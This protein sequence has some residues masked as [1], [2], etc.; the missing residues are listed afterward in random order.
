MNH[1]CANSKTPS[2]EHQNTDKM[3]KL[4]FTGQYKTP[5][6]KYLPGNIPAAAGFNS[7]SDER[8]HAKM[9]P[10]SPVITNKPT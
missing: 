5:F 4:M 3:T 8:T 9:Q 10:R 7:D 6:M 2:F 1:E